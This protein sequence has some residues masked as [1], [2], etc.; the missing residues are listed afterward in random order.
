MELDDLKKHMSESE[1]ERFRGL[2]DTEV[3][4]IGYNLPLMIKKVINC[5]KAVL[6][7]PGILL[8]EQSSLNFSSN[9]EENLQLLRRELVDS[10]ILC[11]LEEL[12]IVRAFDQ[13]LLIDGGILV[14]KG[15]PQKLFDNEDSYLYTYIKATNKILFKKM[16]P[17]V[18][19]E[20]DDA[21]H[22]DTEMDNWRM[23]ENE[24]K[25]TVADD[26]LILDRCSVLKRPRNRG[27]LDGL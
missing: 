7:C 5:V 14:E 22:S 16:R 20:K 21:F 26:R 4:G 25:P 1:I 23:D 11:N 8:V 12:S 10:I 18:E 13:I 24:G 3:E 17:R 2:L 6:K 15:N 19:L 27:G 9:M